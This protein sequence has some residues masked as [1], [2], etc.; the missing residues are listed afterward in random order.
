M[1]IQTSTRTKDRNFQES[2]S[3]MKQ[4]N[5]SNSTSAIP[6]VRSSCVVQPRP[7]NITIKVMA[8]D[9][10]KV[11]VNLSIKTH[12]SVEFLY[13]IGVNDAQYI[14][15]QLV[16]QGAIP[17]EYHQLVSCMLTEQIIQLIMIQVT[18][19]FEKQQKQR[20]QLEEQ[21]SQEVAELIRDEKI[22]YEK[23][24]ATQKSSITKAPGST[25]SDEIDSVF[26]NE[27]ESRPSNPEKEACQ[28]ND[29]AQQLYYL[30]QRN[31]EAQRQEKY[32]Q[33]RLME[34][35][36][37]IM[38]NVG[39]MSVTREFTTP[40]RQERVGYVRQYSLPVQYATPEYSQMMPN[41]RYGH[42][43]YGVGGHYRHYL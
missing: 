20:I 29:R 33:Q 25:N 24:L 36:A 39:R 16:Q 4:Q 9:Y 19:L 38:R 13:E 30:H 17:Q 6:A 21:F 1:S 8:F 10:P 27:F 5:K 31:I 26:S 42:P 18:R 7:E 35:Q 41:M 2:S 28:K 43:T 34:S 37:G 12:K 40:P 15:S 22:Q 3:R 32:R 11:T 23:K 14:S